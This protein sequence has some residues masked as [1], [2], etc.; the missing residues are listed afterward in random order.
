MIANARCRTQSGEG[1]AAGRTSRP[2]L[3]DDVRLLRRGES[4]DTTDAGEGKQAADFAEP[5]DSGA[6][7]MAA[8]PA[9]EK[10]AHNDSSERLRELARRT[11]E[12]IRSKSKETPASTSAE[13]GQLHEEVKRLQ[14]EQQA[15][16]E[17]LDRYE[18]EQ[19]RK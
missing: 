6:L 17:R 11:A 9:I 1:R 15:L 10:I 5:P 12:R 19:K 13:L 2:R 18:A 14:R 4:A 7:A 8:L 16:R 3:A